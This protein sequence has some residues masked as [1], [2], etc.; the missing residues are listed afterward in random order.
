MD[1]IGWGGKELKKQSWHL[2]FKEEY[3][4]DT[5]GSQRF[6]LGEELKSLK[7]GADI[8][9]LIRKSYEHRGPY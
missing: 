4:D 9:Q 3:K 6:L 8:I 1:L 2:S 7:V 5:I